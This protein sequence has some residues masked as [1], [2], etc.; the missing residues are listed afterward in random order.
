[1]D[2]RFQ[3]IKDAHVS[4]DLTQAL[5]RSPAH[6]VEELLAISRISE[7]RGL[8]IHQLGLDEDKLARLTHELERQVDPDMLKEYLMPVPDDQLKSWSFGCLPPAEPPPRPP[9]EARPDEPFSLQE[10]DRTQVNHIPDLGPVRDQGNR[11][12]CVAFG[13][14]CM[15]EF[16]EEKGKDLDLSE[17][18]LYW[19]AKKRDGRENKSGTWIRYAVDC[20][21]E[22]GVCREDYWPYNREK[23]ETEHQGDPPAKAKQDA[24]RYRIAKG[25][26]IQPTSVND[27][28]RCLS[29]DDS[30]AGRV[31]SFAVPVFRSWLSNPITYRTGRIPMPLRG[32]ED[33][34]GHC[35]ALVGYEDNDEYPGGGFFIFRN[36]WGPGWAA[37]CP[38]GAGYGTIPYAFLADNGWEAWTLCQQEKKLSIG[39]FTK[40]GPRL[41]AF[42]VFL[43][44]AGIIGVLSIPLGWWKALP[45]HQE[46]VQASSPEGA[47]IPPAQGTELRAVGGLVEV[48][49]TGSH[50]RLDWETR[51]E[52]VDTALARA[53]LNAVHR[54]GI[55]IQST[56]IVQDRILTENTAQA[57]AAGLISVKNM[58]EKWDGPR[59]TVSITA[60]V[61]IAKVERDMEF[62]DSSGIFESWMKAQQEK[63]ELLKQL[64]SVGD[65][66]RKKTTEKNMVDTRK[67][68]ESMEQF[69][70]AI[71][72]QFANRHTEAIDAYSR[73]IAIR[74]DHAASYNNRGISHETLGQKEEA[75]KDYDSAIG[76]E[77]NY[78]AAHYNRGYAT[79][80]LY[81]NRTEDILKDFDDAIRT[82]PNQ[83]RYY[84]ARALVYQQ[85]GEFDKAMEDF[86]MAIRLMP[87][88]PSAY[89]GRGGIYYERHEYDKA[90]IDW[91]AVLALD[92]ENKKAYFYRG[93]AHHEKG[94]MTKCLADLNKSCQLGHEPACEQARRISGN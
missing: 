61:D 50:T 27:L 29:G 31:V 2:L 19:G 6:T 4:G 38:Y 46:H 89:Y 79:L 37:M 63:E 48:K 55:Y 7:L 67:K 72:K 71:R 22:D 9:D 49:G 81:P 77:P 80:N 84:Y 10:L 66:S 36:S 1:M 42:L 18:Y 58:E 28:R 24:R 91:D 33:I 23:G 43:V 88:F 47:R 83:A 57:I 60:V 78:G 39:K 87:K 12:T 51:E 34:G 82:N 64:R 74:P 45:P 70:D 3:P 20:L 59:V 16:A 14:A 40:K 94:D 53:E 8:L 65:P 30:G 13:T 68:I 41:W 17:Q 54:A 92:P 15:R 85:I 86:N 5:A 62:L 90:I 35:M 52:A 26:P 93:M 75:L 56:R 76:I 11:G 69:E 25:V 21:E 44:A 73:S 32:E